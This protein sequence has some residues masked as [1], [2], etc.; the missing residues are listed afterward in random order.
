MQ[1]NPFPTETSLTSA[2]RMMEWRVTSVHADA[3]KPMGL[4]M[5]QAMSLIYIARH[6]HIRNINQRSI[7]KYL[8]LSNPGVSKIVGFL[9]RAGY[10]TRDPDPSDARSYLLHATDKGIAFAEKLD[11]ILQEADREILKPLTAREQDAFLALLQKIG[12]V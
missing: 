10:V 4:N 11:G 12:N 1:N 3:L 9:E 8:Y 2:L 6:G 7:E 5:Y